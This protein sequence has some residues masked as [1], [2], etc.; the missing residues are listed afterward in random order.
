MR[1]GD[2]SARACALALFAAV[3]RRRQPLDD[4][5]AAALRA[6]RP[7]DRL[8]AR[9]RAFARLL[10]MTTLRRLG[11]ID[12]A[13]ERCLDRPR[14]AARVR[15]VIR[16]GAAQLLFLG[17]PAHA[18]VDATV[19]LAPGDGALKGLVNAVLRRLARDGAAW[20]ADQDAARLNVPDWL[21][22]SWSSTYGEATARAIASVHLGE[23]PLDL[24]LKQPGEKAAARWAQRLD[25][26][27]LPT[28]SLRRAGGGRIEDLEGYR[29][30]A[31]WVQD[32]A[33]ALPARLLA[34][35]L[36]G[37]DE[38]HGARPVRGPG[39]QDR[40]ARRGGRAG[41]RSR[42]VEPA[43][44]AA[45]RQSC[46]TRPRGPLHRR[47]CHD[48]A[49]C[50]GRARCRC[51]S[52][53][54]PVQRHRHNAP[55]SRRGRTPSCRPT[56]PGSSTCKRGCSA[57]RSA[58]CARAPF[59]STSVCSLEPVEGRDQIAAL[60]A[61]HRDLQRV[62][63]EPVEV[64]GQGQFVTTD[65]DL[66]TLPCHFAGAGGLDGFYAARLRRRA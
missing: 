5:W 8:A 35:P 1:K 32:A 65:G 24:T 17:T 10:A 51:G 42:P 26:A 31:W 52:P 6:G 47:R 50:G 66:Q 46:A 54:R 41:D 64:A 28:G 37:F 9:D 18:A 40:A 4:A 38:T 43:A 49:A 55:P 12:A 11:Q 7:L 22:E 19:R 61:A 25:A 57:P 15:D 36:G 2:R 23:P 14:L 58:T 48:L 44:A 39:R 16:L 13:I 62:P 27:V 20:V 59:W 3:V 29:D 60:L 45:R 30:G 63:I 34:E 21:W 53:R 33:A 56:S